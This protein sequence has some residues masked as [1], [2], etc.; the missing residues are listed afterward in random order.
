[1]GTCFSGS[2]RPIA[3]TILPGLF[4]VLYLGK[5]REAAFAETC[6]RNV[7]ATLV[8]ESFLAKRAMIQVVIKPVTL[9]RPTAR[10]SRKSGRRL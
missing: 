5:T 2:P 8:S 4:G 7:G 1:M 9:P 3:S 10:A 6:L